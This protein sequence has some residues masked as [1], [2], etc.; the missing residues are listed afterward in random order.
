MESRSHMCLYSLLFLLF[1]SYACSSSFFS[2]FFS[3]SVRNFCVKPI[4][5]LAWNILMWYGARD[6]EVIFTS[7]IILLCISL[8]TLYSSLYRWIYWEC[9]CRNPSWLYRSLSLSA[10]Y[11]VRLT[12]C[13]IRSLAWRAVS[14]NLILCSTIPFHRL[15]TKGTKNAEQWGLEVV[16]RTDIHRDGLSREATVG[17]VRLI[18]TVATLGGPF[19]LQLIYI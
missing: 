1:R 4:S 3:H 5:C 10:P 11:L 15:S 13:N 6:K 14:F 12:L 9:A 18:I 7:R 2:L 16:C 19:W 17:H 8:L